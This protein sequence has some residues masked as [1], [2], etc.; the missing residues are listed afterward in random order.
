MHTKGKGSLKF[1][2]GPSQSVG[3]FKIQPHF[4]EESTN[5]IF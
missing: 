4:L 3:L 5:K 1:K 2:R